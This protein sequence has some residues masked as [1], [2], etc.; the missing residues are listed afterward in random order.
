MKQTH[1]KFLLSDTELN[2]IAGGG[3]DIG[4]VEN[5]DVNGQGGSDVIIGYVG[6]TV[7]YTDAAESSGSWRSFFAFS[8][9]FNG[10]ISV[11]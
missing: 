10:G 9:R 4:T 2:A 3:I 6:N 8:P 11:S 7:I 1:E 5:L